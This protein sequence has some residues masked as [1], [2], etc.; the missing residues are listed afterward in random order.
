VR[1]YVRLVVTLTVIAG[2][3][4]FGLSM[5]YNATHAITEEYKRQE[6][7]SAR[8]EALGCSAGAVFE[9]TV[10]DSVVDGRAFVYYTAYDES[11][12]NV[13]GYAFTAFGKGYSSTIETVVG[14]TPDGRI[15]GIKIISQKETPGLGAK[16]QEVASKNTLWAVLS[17][18]AV[19]EEGVRPWFQQQFDGLGA[20]DLVVVKSRG[21]NGILAITGATISSDAVTSSIRRGLEMLLKITQGRPEEGMPQ[22][23]GEGLQPGLPGGLIPPVELDTESAPPGEAPRETL[24]GGTRGGTAQGRTRSGA[25]PGRI[26][27]AAGPGDGNEGGGK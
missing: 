8:V 7:A 9:E 18:K 13:L 15:C 1:S 19:S 2:A 3:A 12:Q 5:V 22:Q 26:T 10:T 14:V 27:G 25:S 24:P 16:T 11:H 6:Q 21:E 17:G 4:S 23:P 20:D